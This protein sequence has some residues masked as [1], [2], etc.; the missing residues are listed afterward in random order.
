MTFEEAMEWLHDNDATLLMRYASSEHPMV[1]HRYRMKIVFDV[2]DVGPSPF[3]IATFPTWDEPEEFQTAIIEST[4]AIQKQ[5]Q[6]RME[7]VG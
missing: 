4:Q 5:L 6:A 2:V 1:I 7:A 3:Q